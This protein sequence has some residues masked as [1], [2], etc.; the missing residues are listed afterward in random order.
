MHLILTVFAFGCPQAHRWYQLFMC[1]HCLL[2]LQRSIIFIRITLIWLDS[3]IE[4][5]VIHVYVLDVYFC[6]CN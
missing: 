5:V 3:R 2:Y 1:Y 6:L 4:T